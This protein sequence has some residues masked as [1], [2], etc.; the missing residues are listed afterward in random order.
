M[1][2]VSVLAT[3]NAGAMAAS[4]I[5]ASIYV[6]LT[7]AIYYMAVFIGIVIVVFVPLYM[8]YKHRH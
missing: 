7:N 8:I 5:W 2:V 1:F 3:M 6:V 4:L